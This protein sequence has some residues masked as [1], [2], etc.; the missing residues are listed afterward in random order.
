MIWVPRILTAFFFLGSL[1]LTGF[2]AFHF[3]SLGFTVTMAC[4]SAIFGYMVSY[5]IR[6]ALGK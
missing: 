2:A 1:V 4:M 5:D 6:K 3:R